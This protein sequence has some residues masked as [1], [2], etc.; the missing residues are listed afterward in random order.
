MKFYNYLIS[1]QFHYYHT[2]TPSTLAKLQNSSSNTTSVTLSWTFSL[3]GNAEIAGMDISYT[4]IANFNPPHS[5][6]TSITDGEQ[7]SFTIYGLQPLTTYRFN[8]TV[9]S[10]YCDRNQTSSPVTITADTLP[11]GKYHA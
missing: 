5:N 9:R 4:A 10:L 2:V 3:S 7:N 11:L 8:V 6:S 1:F